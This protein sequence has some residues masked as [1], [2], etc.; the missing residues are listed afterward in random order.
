M[1]RELGDLADLFDRYVCT[2]DVRPGVR[3]IV[4]D[5]YGVDPRS[6]LFI[7]DVNYVGEAVR[8]LG[9]AFI[10]VPSSA[11]W[12]WQRHDMEANRMPCIVPNLASIDDALLDRVD[13]LAG[14]GRFWSG[15]PAPAPAP[16]VTGD[17][18]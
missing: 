4:E 10:G 1:R 7:D 15:R 2:N 13:A 16:A 8:D 3:E 12:S 14:A 9:A 18:R 17:A 11:P 6:A 5:I